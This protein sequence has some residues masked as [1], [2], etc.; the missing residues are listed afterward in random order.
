V[1]KRRLAKTGSGQTQGKTHQKTAGILLLHSPEDLFFGQVNLNSKK[2]GHDGGGWHSHWTGGGTDGIGQ[3]NIAASPDDFMEENLQNL[4]L[5]YPAGVGPDS[6]A[7]NV[8]PGSHLFRDPD[9]CRGGLHSD[10]IQKWL[11]GKVHPV[12][13]EP[14]EELCV[15]LPPGSM[16]CINSHGAHAVGPTAARHTNPR[17][18]MSFFYFRRSARTGHVQPPAWLTPAWALKAVRGE[19]PPL[20]TELFRNAWDSELTGGRNTMQQP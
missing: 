6:G 17:L 5:T 19:L 9:N 10:A 8:I 11:D 7:I 16:V 15:P 14:M 4:N 13:G 3:P 2:P 18:A 1:D 12:T 20:L